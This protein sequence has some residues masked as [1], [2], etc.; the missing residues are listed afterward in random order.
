MPTGSDN[1]RGIKR[2]LKVKDSQMEE[3]QRLLEY[4]EE[5]QRIAE[6]IGWDPKEVII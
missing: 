3:A 2:Y 5:V 6:E 1:R 4:I